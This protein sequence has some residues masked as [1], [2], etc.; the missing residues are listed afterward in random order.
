MIYLIVVTLLLLPAY[1]A[2]IPIGGFPG[3]ALMLWVIIAWVT[4]CLLFSVSRQWH[5]FFTFISTIDKKILLLTGLFLTAGI[6]SL[7]VGGLN[8]RNLGQLFVLFV[9]PTSLFFIAGFTFQENP[10]YKE[11]VLLIFY[12]ILGA[13]GLYALLQY[14]ALLGLPVSFQGNMAEPKRATGFFIHP[15]FYSLFSVPLLA[16]LIPDVFKRAQTALSHNMLWIG[17]WLFGALGLL[18]S[19]SRA[20]WIGLGAVLFFYTAFA[21][22]RTVKKIS[23]GM[24]LGLIILMAVTPSLRQRITAP[25][26]GEK[27][28]TSRITLWKSGIK[29]I[30]ESPFLGLGINGFANKYSSLISDPTLDTHNFPHNIFLDF[31]VETG[32][33]GLI[34]FM[35]LAW[36]F[37]SRGFLIRKQ[38][39]AAEQE[40]RAQRKTIK[41][42]AWLDTKTLSLSI[43]LFFIALIFQGL[44]DNPYFKNDL[45]M[46]FW[47]VLSLAL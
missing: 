7:F 36:L 42:P 4:T 20:G 14:V 24:L 37:I 15:N 22:T 31:W 16:L 45:A 30:K 34:S 29:G 26:H 40:R 32:L 21:A 25:F 38:N 9:Q 17:L 18:V 46:I 3:D 47:I 19:F 10:K 6:I 5:K 39:T 28:A 44:I 11:H 35:G 33:L 43:S 12:F 8:T 27:S 41:T 13:M 23:L 1:A 2:K